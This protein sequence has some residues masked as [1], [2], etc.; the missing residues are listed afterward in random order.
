MKLAV[1]ASA[2]SGWM[3]MGA[4]VGASTDAAGPAG[5]APGAGR[6]GS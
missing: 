5:A 4:T 6:A 2:G 1:G 3:A